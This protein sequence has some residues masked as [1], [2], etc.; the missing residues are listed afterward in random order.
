MYAG[1]MILSP[2]KNI[3]M[4]EISTEMDNSTTFQVVKCLQQVAHIK[5]ATIVMSLLQP[6]P[7]TFN[8]FD[9]VIIM[10]EGQIVYHGPRD[11]VLEFFE[12]CGFMCPERKDIAD[13]LQEV[14]I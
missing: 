4:D 8:L 12:Y 3:F 14:I 10:S 9:D 11:H 2:M 1:E 13:F 6:A 5:Q 7:E